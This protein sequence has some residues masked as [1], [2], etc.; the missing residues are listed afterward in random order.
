MKRRDFIASTSIV[1][2]GSSLVQASA[3]QTTSSPVLR[4]AHVTDTHIEPDGPSANGVAAALRKVQSL[5][6]KA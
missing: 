4:I 1:T 3:I 6:K 5:K 2:L